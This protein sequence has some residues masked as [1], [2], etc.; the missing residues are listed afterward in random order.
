MMNYSK[1]GCQRSKFSR[2]S[3]HTRHK[4]KRE[5]VLPDVPGRGGGTGS[6]LLPGGPAGGCA[7][8]GARPLRRVR[9]RSAAERWRLAAKL[10]QVI[11]PRL[12]LRS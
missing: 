12:P 11:R 4:S 9:V 1:Q 3:E 5:G 8:R 7:R 10:R 6:R 2:W